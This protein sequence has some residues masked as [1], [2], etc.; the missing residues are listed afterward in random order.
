MGINR[1]GDEDRGVILWDFR[2]VGLCTYFKTL[3]IS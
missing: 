3:F 1:L 2:V